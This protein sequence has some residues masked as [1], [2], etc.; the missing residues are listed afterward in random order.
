ML[1]ATQSTINLLEQAQS[2]PITNG[3]WIEYNMNSLISGVSIDAPE[4]VKTATKTVD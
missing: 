2:L 1:S 3:C 4:G